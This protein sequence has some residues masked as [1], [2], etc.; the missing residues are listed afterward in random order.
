MEKTL[1]DVQNIQ[2]LIQK[3][4]LKEAIEEI[5]KFVQI[6]ITGE[7]LGSLM[8]R[9]EF[10]LLNNE[11]FSLNIQQKL[12]KDENTKSKYQSLKGKLLEFLAKLNS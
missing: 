12:K 7:D 8:L 4:E 3:N 5:K 11:Y 10:R 2:I 9:N 6:T 1:L